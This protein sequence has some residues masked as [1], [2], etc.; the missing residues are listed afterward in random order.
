MTQLP[1]VSSTS[2]R[3]HRNTGVALF[4]ALM[5]I[6]VLAG[7]MLL[8]VD[9]AVSIDQQASR[10]N[11]GGR[12][13][14][15][16][17]AVLLRREHDV[18][19]LAT[20][21]DAGNFANWT[22]DGKSE[23]ARDTANG[24]GKS[25]YGLDT[26][27]GYA[28]RWKI[29]PARTAPVSDVNGQ[30]AIP[31][32]ANPSPDPTFAIPGSSTQIPN[33]ALYLYRIAAEARLSGNDDG[34]R[35][36]QGVRYVSLN[37]EPLFRYV[38]FYA[39]RGPK[40]DLELSHADTVN[41]KGS[42][43]T[44]GS[45]YIGSGLKVN[46]K[47]A[48]RGSINGSLQ[49]SQTIIGPDANNKDVRVNGLDGI[50]R[51]SK[52]LMY[53]IINGFPLSDTSGSVV[54]AGVPAGSWDANSSYDTGNAVVFPLEDS[55]P[56]SGTPLTMTS[57]GTWI[58]PYRIKDG[59]GAITQGI[60]DTSAAGTSAR[61]INGTAILGVGASNDSRD[62]PRTN[63]G[64]VESR[65]WTKLAVTDFDNLARSKINGATYKAVQGNMNRGL[66]AQALSY[67]D[68]DGNPL[69]DQHEYARPQFI[70]S[71]NGTTTTDVFTSPLTTPLIENPGYYVG[72][73][74]GNSANAM[75]RHTNGD[76]WSIRPKSDPNGTPAEGLQGGLLI[77]ERPIPQT[78]YW[79]GANAANYLDSTNPRY[80]P[81]AY[82]KHWYPTIAPFTPTDVSDNLMRT[83]R[84][85][86]GAGMVSQNFSTATAHRVANYNGSG[87]LTVTA[88]ANPG[89]SHANNGTWSSYA[90][91]SYNSI[92]RKLYFYRDA[93]RFIHL[94]KYT[95]DTA[96]NGLALYYYK[97]Q[98][99]VST[100]EDTY[101]DESRSLQAP[102]PFASG[103]ASSVISITTPAD[104][105]VS[106]SNG[107]LSWASAPATPSTTHWSARWVGFYK[108]SATGFHTFTGS[109][110][111]ASSQSVRLWVD[112]QRV[113]EVNMSGTATTPNALNLSSSRYYPIVVE[114]ASSAT[115]AP[116]A[117]PTLRAGLLG[118]TATTIPAANLFPPATTGVPPIINLTNFTAVQCRIDNPQGLTNP[119]NAKVGLMIRPDQ[120]ISPL[121]QGGS[122]YAMIGWS[123]SRGF[124]TQ[125]RGAPA[126]QSQRN[127]GTYY[128][129]NGTGPNGDANT[130][131]E[132][133]DNPTSVA[134]VSR[135]AYF[136]EIYRSPTV[137]SATSYTPNSNKGSANITSQPTP[138]TGSMSTD[139]GGG[140]IWQ[141][142][143][144][145][146][147]GTYNGS[148]L[149]TPTKTRTI[150]KSVVQTLQLYGD[151][152]CTPPTIMA[153]TA[154]LVTADD[155]S[156]RSIAFFTNSTGTTS[157]GNGGTV[158]SSSKVWWFSTATGTYD[159]TARRVISRY[160]STSWTSAA[161]NGTDLTQTLTVGSSGTA[162]ASGN[163]QISKVG[164]ITNA[165]ASDLATVTGLPITSI[166]TSLTPSWPAPT[167][168][169]GNYPADG[170]TPL[171]TT[172]A[173]Q[174]ADPTFPDFTNAG[175]GRTFS[176]TRGSTSIWF[177]MNPWITTSMAWRSI[178][179]LQYL[180][181]IAAWPTSWIG[182]VTTWPTTF[183]QRPDLWT[184]GTAQTAV[185]TSALASTAGATRGATALNINGTVTG[186]NGYA[187]ADD[188]Q[189]TGYNSS[190][191][192]EVWLRIEKSGA[193]LVYK[194]FAGTT[195]PTGA[196]DSR[197]YTLGTLTDTTS[198][199]PTLLMGPCVQSGSVTTPITANFS[200]LRIETTL[201]SPY[202]IIDGTDWD[203]SSTGS[204]DDLSKYLISQYQVFF[205][206]REITEDF[207]TWR[208]VNGR[209]L[210]SEDWFFQP[211]EFWS[212]SR[213]WDHTTNAGLAIEKDPFTAPSTTF[214]STV[215]RRLL[216][217]TTVL[218]LDMALIQQYLKERTFANA[219]ADRI[220]GIGSAP[221][222][223]ANP[224]AT[225]A[226]AFNGIIYAARTNR[227]PWNPH[228][229]PHLASVSPAMVG[230]NP[231]SPFPGLE[232]P[233]SIAAPLVTTVPRVINGAPDD[234]VKDRR[235]S[236]WR[237][238]DLLVDGV[239]KLEPYG[240]TQAPAFMPQRFH[241]GIRIINGQNINIKYPTGATL[242]GSNV[243]GGGDWS[244]A[245]PPSFGTCRLS[246][247]TPNQLYVQGSLN[248]NRYLVKASGAA[249]PQYKYSPMA[250]MGDQI[251]LLSNAWTDTA[252]QV[253]D[254][255]VTN[256]SPGVSGNG[257]L[258]CAN[259]GSTAT[260][261]SYHAGIVTNNI[262]TTKD[263]VLEA[264]AAP[265]V[266][267]TLFLENWN[268]VQMHYLGSLVVLDS[269]RY[270]NSFL[271]GSLKTYGTTPF[272]IVAC[273]DVTS[274]PNTNW[275]PFFGVGTADW[276]GRSPA[277]YSEP[278]RR[279]EFN[280]D[281]MNSDGTPPFVPFGVSSGGIGGWV[282][283]FE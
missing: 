63:N 253:D 54:S 67:V 204:A 116:A 205:G 70:N 234:P 265:F 146:S 277:V 27:N 259:L 71:G 98:G 105:I 139:V 236:F 101:Y 104:H 42:I 247:V 262:P 50:F 4:L 122:A 208:D 183:G 248:V 276:T 261:T 61:T 267:T 158:G 156:N 41:I 184:S 115:G 52:P 214:T 176:I 237:P 34:V 179:E 103:A 245:D 133:V 280:Y 36:A 207:L 142:L 279:Y 18:A 69:T 189:P 12:A 51:L 43:H 95:V 2:L 119:A 137:T 226:S 121:Q 167:I 162:W 220:A 55:P 170:A 127:I 73:A 65:K 75:V 144:P 66:E 38:L 221:L 117:A 270:S 175:N 32:V 199:G 118:A 178:A 275:L 192:T 186:G 49:P 256:T 19:R 68:A 96:R 21:G 74:L 215:N 24:L 110:A 85:D 86:G 173:T 171:P 109:T 30:N 123:P 282:R 185:N 150:T 62:N 190:T 6:G 155:T 126:K 249:T 278:I 225:L 177:D 112:G 224:S 113:W 258:V 260:A 269:R 83:W 218:S 148:R 181:K 91:S 166:Q 130:A 271:L 196:T 5:V 129:G 23:D 94:G 78:D 268:G 120:A 194:C 163:I 210:V 1:Q 132:I 15:A 281:F 87:C 223:N 264:Q 17:E 10:L 92:Q 11:E 45:L 108:P 200:N 84:W 153:G 157:F 88:A 232:Y 229:A 274:P 168:P 272:G 164:V 219:T 203:S 244:Y 235:L 8:A 44:N 188:Y 257:S 107:L 33:D 93:W 149:V 251:T 9:Q 252:Y 136:K 241:H 254:L 47:V 97:D 230:T 13:A 266:D 81:Y 273:S 152:G 111:G 37:R 25:N 238:A 212:Q 20:L 14:A 243:E 106:T 143:T 201:A 169:A 77:R 64:T 7:I 222:T 60:S 191:T 125:V 3:V 182:G 216:G 39:Q 53:G 180:P 89:S 59:S 242:A 135:T 147:I 80:M 172:P 99:A 128:I 90:G 159:A 160:Y 57:G 202:D 195:P 197:W 131:G 28:V 161:V 239:H 40:G 151:V 211:R 124:F 233:N 31:F 35:R 56:A 72:L 141:I 213:Y 250:I 283:S 263:R 22:T 187:M 228:G 174:P 246:V 140:K 48:Q 165:T 82:G 102:L 227:Y 100:V 76:G 26:I 145:F 154:P 138:Y 134:T 217:K 255:T 198:W 79:P 16:V 46:D 193:N 231:Y 206:T 114:L 209:R 29:E 58:N 240:L